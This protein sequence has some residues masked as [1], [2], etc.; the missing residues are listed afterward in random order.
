VCPVA[1]PPKPAEKP[2]QAAEWSDLP[3]WNEDDPGPVFA[4]F[5]ASCTSLERQAQWKPVCAAARALDDS[6][7]PALRAWFEAQFRPWALVNPDGSRNGII[8]GY[9][10]PILNGSRTGGGSYSHPVF[11]PP[12]DMI[13]VGEAPDGYQAIELSASLQSD[14]ILMDIAMPGLG[15]LE[16]TTEIRKRAPRPRTRPVLW[17]RPP[18]RSTTS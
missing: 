15:G 18:A 4:A 3:G 1:E 13:V 12:D 8:T 2:L 10:E 16:A 5:V 9:Y 7:A 11:G 6:S 14:L 17:R